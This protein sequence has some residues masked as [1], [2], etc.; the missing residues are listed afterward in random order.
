L[1]FNKKEGQPPQFPL[2]ASASAACALGEMLL[3]RLQS[4]PMWVEG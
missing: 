3:L 2:L 1:G 4:K